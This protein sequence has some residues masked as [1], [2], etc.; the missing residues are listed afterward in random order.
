MLYKDAILAKIKSSQCDCGTEFTNNKFHSHLHHYDIV[1]CLTCPYTP[2]QNSI[3]E[4]KHFHVI[5]ID[6]TFCPIL[7]CHFLCG[8]RPSLLSSFSLTNSRHR[9]LMTK[10]F[11]S[12]CLKNNPI[13]LCFKLLGVFTF[14]IW[15]IPHL[16]NYLQ[17]VLNVFFR[18]VNLHKG[19]ECLDQKTHRV[20]VSRYM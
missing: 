20:Y 19:F 2:S 5:K 15:E 6:L 16:I 3:H 12:S 8:L 14:L 17:N 7:V 4:H 13:T 10:L 11:M 1:L 18:L 9:L